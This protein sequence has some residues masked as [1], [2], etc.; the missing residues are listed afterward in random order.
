LNKS[1]RD[2]SSFTCYCC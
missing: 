2:I 1:N